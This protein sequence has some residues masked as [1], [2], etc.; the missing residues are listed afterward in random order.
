MR[1]THQIAFRD[2]RRVFNLSPAVSDYQ[3]M[4]LMDSFV[5]K[6]ATEVEYDNACIN[7]LAENGW[8]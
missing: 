7:A 5:G 8:I 4:E 3:V 2:A 1:N 6:Y